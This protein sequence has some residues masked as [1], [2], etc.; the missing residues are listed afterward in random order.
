MYERACNYLRSLICDL[1]T[2]DYDI[3]PIIA[4]QVELPPFE[5]PMM[6]TESV[7]EMNCGS[8]KSPDLGIIFRTARTLKKL[9]PY[10][11]ISQMPQ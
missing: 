11:N 10:K 9:P 8:T 3:Y 5:Y 4:C 6:I 2:I 1:A 7:Q